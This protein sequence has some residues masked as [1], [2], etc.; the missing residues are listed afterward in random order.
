M[1]RLNTGGLKK[2]GFILKWW[3]MRGWESTYAQRFDH[4]LVVSQRDGEL[5]RSA[6]PALPLS[7]IENGVDTT[8]YQPLREASA[9]NVLLLVGTIGYPPNRDAVIYFC[10]AILPLIQRRIPDVELYVVGHVPP[11]E[12]QKLATRN[13]IVVT[14]SV[15]DV[16]PYYRQARVTIIPLRGGGG[17]RLKVLESMALGRPVVS[18]SLGCEGLNVVDG[19]HIMIADTPFEFAERVI[20]LLQDKDLRA[21]ICDNAWQL[22]KTQYD[23]SVISRNLIA[24]YLDFAARGS[25]L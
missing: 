10:R 11:P 21:R 18:T 15:P 23:W 25:M 4:C 24:V 2:L 8:T 9:G 3:M 13:N 7:V 1:I 17:T 22:V 16:L 5:L 12:V 19:E 20:C 14:G 6:N